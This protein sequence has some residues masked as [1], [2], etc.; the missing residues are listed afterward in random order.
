D[1]AG[2]WGGSFCPPTPPADPLAAGAAFTRLGVA[3]ASAAL[4]PRA[5]GPDAVA[6]L[7]YSGLLAVAGRLE[8]SHGARLYGAVAV[9]AEASLPGAPGREP[10]QVLYD[11][12]FG[13]GAWPPPERRRPR[14][15]W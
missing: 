5:R 14:T 3:A 10:F 15:V 2:L 7:T 11:E 8:S 9:G 13:R 12:R 4:A 1:G 6:S